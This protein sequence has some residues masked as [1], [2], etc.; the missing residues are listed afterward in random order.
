MFGSDP[1]VVGREAELSR[2]SRF[3]S[4]G[5][6]SDVAVLTGDAGVGKTTVWD[7]GLSLARNGGSQVLVSRASESELQLSFVALSDLLDGVDL[8]ALAGEV[9]VPQLHALEVALLRRESDGTSA[10]TLAV[11]GG[12]TR[13]VRALA[14]Q[15]SLVVAID[16]MP[17][18]D[19]PSMQVIAFAARR[20]RAGA[21]RFLFTRRPGAASIVE[22][23]CA[24]GR[25]ERVEIGPLSLGAVRLL[26]AERLELRPPRRVLL[27]LFDLSQGNPLVA[28]ELGRALVERGLPDVG[29]ELPLPQLVDDLFAERIDGLAPALKRSVLAVSLTGSLTR[30]EL[31]ALVGPLAMEDALAAGLL[32]LDGSRVRASHPLLA[33]T[34]RRHSTADE[35]RALH[36]AL[37]ETIDDET[38]RVHHLALATGRRNAALADRMAAAAARAAGRGAV[39]DAVS[40]AEQAMRLTPI[41]APEYPERLL[42]FARYLTIAGETARVRDLLEA[43]LAELPSGSARARAL[44]MLSDTGG[45]MT[46]EACLDAALAECGDDAALRSTALAIRALMFALVRFCMLDEAERSAREALVLARPAGAEAQARAVHALAWI[47]VLRGRPVD[48]PAELFGEAPSGASLY[49]SAIERPVGIRLMLRGHV[50]ESRAVFDRLRALAGERGEA[51]S[52]SVLHRQLCEIELRAGDVFAAEH[53]LAEWG[54]WTLP[55]DAHEQ[56]LGPARCRALLEAVRG[57]ADDCERWAAEAIPVATEVENYREQTEVRRALGLAALRAHE[58]ARAVQELLP[59]WQHAQREGIDDPGAVPVAPDL[60][61]ALVEQGEL[62]EARAVTDRLSRLAD[63]Q[64]H[65]WATA[66]AARCRAL[67]SFAASDD[68]ERAEEEMAAV[69][70][71]YLALGLRFDAARTLL[72]LGRAQRRRRKWAAARDALAAAETAFAALGATGWVEEAHAESARVGARRATPSGTLSP[73]EELVA[74]LAA[75]GRS[76]KQIAGELHV[77]ANTVEK[78]LSRVYAKVGVRSRAELAARFRERPS[79][80]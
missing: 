69:V 26:L 59:L 40:V 4:D 9:P 41:A 3:L 32:L 28:L 65:P 24:P 38:L 67:I 2:V 73:T 46:M 22:R 35:R 27:R 64:D 5:D 44:L 39:H 66:G 48:E 18:L 45:S 55:G 8:S 77:T 10:E 14:E 70:T 25:L 37:A 54:E 72:L 56:V 53:H 79:G 68:V 49:E 11:A 63:E 7:A 19:Q 52:A 36:R 71:D 20:L 43:R 31:S 62:A 80:Q 74:A 76:N 34:V 57:G 75:Q 30:L 17:W 29:Q 23:A 6:A 13:V 78:H 21:V 50:D 51:L 12:F 42:D 33:A 58:P 16:D 1:A 60:V 15:R 61:E 47:N